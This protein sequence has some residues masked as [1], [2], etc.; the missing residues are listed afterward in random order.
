MESFSLIDRA[1][2]NPLVGNIEYII[3]AAIIGEAVAGR[4]IRFAHAS[5]DGYRVVEPVHGR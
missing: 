5:C 3:A 2:V 4:E 1:I